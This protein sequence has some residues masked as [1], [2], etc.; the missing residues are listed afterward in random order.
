MVEELGSEKYNELVEENRQL[1]KD[2]WVAFVMAGH[3]ECMA[4]VSRGDQSEENCAE[5][6]R[7]SLHAK[8]NDWQQESWWCALQDENPDILYERYPFRDVK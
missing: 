7:V 1:N 4:A 3:R 2:R 6:T 8:D 5:H